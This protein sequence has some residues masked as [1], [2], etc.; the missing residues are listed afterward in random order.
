VKDD[1]ILKVD[2]L[3]SEQEVLREEMTALHTVKDKLK[4]RIS[5]L[6]D[7]LKRVKE[8]TAKAGKSGKSDDEVC[9][10]IRFGIVELSQDGTSRG[11]WRSLRQT[12]EP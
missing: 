10:R 11:E 2:E 12:H 6:E 4:T 9:Y 7:E 3:T 8:E 1:L 5:E